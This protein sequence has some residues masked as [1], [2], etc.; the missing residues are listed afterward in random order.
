RFRDKAPRQ[1]WAA[2]LDEGTYLCSVSTM[3]RLLPTPRL[4]V[5]WAVG[6]LSRWIVMVCTRVVGAGAVPLRALKRWL[7]RR[8]LRGALLPGL[9]HTRHRVSSATARARI[10]TRSSGGKSRV[11]P[12][13]RAANETGSGLETD[14]VPLR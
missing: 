2:L 10:H 13:D 3:Y 6:G 11:G 5:V 8:R 12:R 4:Y 7:A 14:R 9:A 1:V